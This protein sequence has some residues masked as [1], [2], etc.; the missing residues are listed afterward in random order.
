MIRWGIIGAGDIAN[1]RVA[2]AISSLENATL[3]A[4]MRRDYEKAKAFAERHRIPKVYTSLDDLLA[5]REIDA[6]YIS[7]PIFLHAPQA[8]Q[9]L[10]AG[11]HV[12]V[13]KPMAMTVEEGREMIEMARKE[14]RTL[15]VA[16]FRRFYPKVERV[17][18]LLEDGTLGDV[19]M[20]V[21]MYHTWYDPSPDDP[22]AWRVHK[23]RAGGGVLWD[24]G[25]HRFDLLIG[26]FG[27][28]THLF[29][30]TD[31]LTHSYEVED[32]ASIFMRFRNGSHCV[33]TWNWNSKT[34]VD[35]LSIVGTKAKVILEPMDSENLTLIIGKDRRQ[36]VHEEKI[37]LPENVH[38]PMIRDFVQALL[39]G[40]PPLESGEEGLKTN[41]ILEAIERSAQMRSEVKICPA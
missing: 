33:S 26:L 37:P 23:G 32:T 12:L 4:V 14:G 31:T 34:W 15:G 28:P 19:V 17:R 9:A 6:V 24:M 7:T 18:E 13:E 38:L 41:I 8:I 29:A 11:K 35:H 21:S 25:S 10:R 2:P 16:Y 36:E 30:I 5:D 20:V 40:R 27:M 3:V 22:K 1:K 39:E